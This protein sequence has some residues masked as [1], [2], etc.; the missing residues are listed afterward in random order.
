MQ[1]AGASNRP[2]SLQPEGQRCERAVCGVAAFVDSKGYP[3]R[4]AP[5]I[6]SRPHRC[7]TPGRSSTRS[8]SAQKELQ[9]VSSIRTISEEEKRLRVNAAITQVN[10]ACGS[11]TP[12][13]QEPARVIVAPPAYGHGATTR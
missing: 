8:K 2:I 4:T 7:A 6:P 10:A 11:Q 9:F 13:M 1:A 3:L 12:L 5:C